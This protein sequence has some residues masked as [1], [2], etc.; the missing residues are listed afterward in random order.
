LKERLPRNFVSVYETELDVCQFTPRR[1][2]RYP[3]GCWVVDLRLDDGTTVRRALSMRSDQIN[4]F[5]FLSWHYILVLLAASGILA[6]IVARMVTAPLAQL[7]RAALAIG[8]DLDDGALPERGS[9]EVR[10]AAQAFDTMRGRLKKN[11]QERTHML[12]SIAHDLQ[13]PL[14]RMRLKIENVAEPEIR[15]RLFADVAAMQTLVREGLDLAQSVEVSEPFHLLDVDSLLLSMAQDAVDAG[16]RVKFTGGCG[17]QVRARPQCLQRCI[18]NLL[19]N[20]LK[21]AGEAEVTSRLDDQGVVIVVRDFGDGIPQEAIGTVMEPFVRV[22]ASR[23]RKTG[24][25]GLGLAIAQILA[26]KNN[27]IIELHNH[28]DGGLVASIKFLE[29]VD[30]PSK[31]GKRDERRALSA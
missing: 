15:K 26:G 27:A 21:F 2:R 11:L 6:F 3:E 22:E 12:A 13:T 8:L 20:A 4:P 10:N 7:S 18:A 1:T 30:R 17:A 9:I 29:A 28:P 23:S 16:Q 31:T 25:V 19:E 5:D 14:T 24:G